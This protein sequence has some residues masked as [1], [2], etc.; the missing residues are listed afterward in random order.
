M[1]CTDSR[2]APSTHPFK[3]ERVC[4]CI[5]AGEL[6]ASGREHPSPCVVRAPM[7]ELVL[8]CAVRS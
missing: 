8:R 1:Q 3:T 4:V 5:S 2:N 7:P 6:K